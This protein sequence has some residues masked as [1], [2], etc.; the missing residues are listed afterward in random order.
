MLSVCSFRPWSRRWVQQTDH[1]TQEV[2]AL[3]SNLE[4][5]VKSKN[6]ETPRILRNQNGNTETPV[7]GTKRK[8]WET[9]NQV[10]MKRERTVTWAERTK[11]QPK[12]V[13]KSL[14]KPARK[15]ITGIETTPLS[16]LSRAKIGLRRKWWS[17]CLVAPEIIIVL[18]FLYL[19]SGYI[20][21][22][23]AF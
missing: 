17:E 19:T 10:P 21:T 22:W 15:S 23:E 13:G 2:R 8:R 20:V 14:L 5:G 1:L 9:E 4:K 12:D 6:P 18:I 3:R 16:K 7:S 11:L